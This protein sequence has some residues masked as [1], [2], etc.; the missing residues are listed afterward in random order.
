MRTVSIAFSAAISLFV[1]ASPA[2]AADI[3]TKAPPPA[4]TQAYN[5]TG[6]YAGGTFGGVFGHSEHC[7]PPYVFCTAPFDIAGIAGGPTLGYNW[8]AT[9]GLPVMPNWVYGLETDFS[10]SRATGGTGSIPGVYGCGGG[11]FTNVDWF[12]TVRGRVGPSF[13]NW[14]PYFTGGLV[15][16]RIS[17]GIA[18]AILGEDS[19]IAVKT[20][21][22]IGGG[23]E[24]AIPGSARWSVKLEYLYFPMH[25]IFYDNAHVCGGLDCTAVLNQFNV[26][27]LGAN[28]RF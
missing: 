14:F 18:A 27:R 11:C 2:L 16:A 15:Y 1:F 8:Q 20:D 4:A 6:L 10:W 25:N 17:P 24:Y 3:P 7:D 19:A 9:I 12:G 28:Y 22:T 26:L 13:N 5:W 21:W 23:I